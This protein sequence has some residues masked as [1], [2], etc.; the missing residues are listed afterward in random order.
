MRFLTPPHIHIFFFILFNKKQ[1]PKN[2]YAK[3]QPTHFSMTPQNPNL[4]KNVFRNLK[5]LKLGVPKKLT[6][7]SQGKVK[8]SFP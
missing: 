8:P 3:K 2:G 5:I 1:L 7:I 6:P 4:K